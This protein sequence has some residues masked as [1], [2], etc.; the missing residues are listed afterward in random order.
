[1]KLLQILI[2]FVSVLVA[3]AAF[4]GEAP[5]GKALYAAKCASCHGADGKGETPVG[6]AMNVK[7]L[8]VPNWAA[9]DAAEKIAT[10]IRDGVPGM[11]PMGS[12]LSEAEI[13]AVSKATRDMAVAATAE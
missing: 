2:V 11:P 6:K 10:A 4:A 13:D 12:A 9:E 8:L 1:M 7:S 3:G 5:D